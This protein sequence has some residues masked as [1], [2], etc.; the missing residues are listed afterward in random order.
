VT[1]APRLGYVPAL[2]GL[3]GVAIVLVVGRHAFLRPINGGYGVDLFFVLS[4]YLITTLLLE[5]RE[6]SSGISLRAFYLRRAR[7]LMPALG[8]MLAC[9]LAAMAAIGHA[10]VAARRTAAAGFYTANIMQA[11]WPHVIGRSPI[12]PL[13]SLAQEEQ[14]YLV[15]PLLVLVLLRWRS[16]AAMR[17]LVIGAIAFVTIERLT[18]FHLGAA[19]QRLYAGPDTHSDG[20]LLGSLLALTLRRSTGPNAT[21]TNCMLGPASLV[22][23]GFLCVSSRFPWSEGVSFVDL[24]ALGLVCAVVC[25]PDAL[26]TRALTSWPLVGLGKISYSLYLWNALFLFAYHG[27]AAGDPRYR[28]T[29]AIIDVA[30]AIVVSSLSYRF[31]EQRFRRRRNSRTV[32][33]PPPATP[34]LAVGARGQLPLTPGSRL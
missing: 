18:L 15:F 1:R 16:E 7:R 25:Q 28:T 10:A 22:L 12:G 11:W 34:Q 9:Y 31:I 32:E 30:A 33:L 26:I 29:A 17:L 24:A 21:R 19:G 27:D 6:R 5:E 2:D 4:G 20:L 8:F 14:F 13:W 23:L 3:R